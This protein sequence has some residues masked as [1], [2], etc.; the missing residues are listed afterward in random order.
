MT[1]TP[2]NHEDIALLIEEI[3]R[4]REG[5]A[6]PQADPG[7]WERTVRHFAGAQADR[8]VALLVELRQWRDRSAG[9]L[10]VRGTHRVIIEGFSDVSSSAALSDALDKASHY[11]SEQHDVSVTLQQLVELPKGGHRATVELHMTPLTEKDKAHP[12]GQDVEMKRLHERDYV[13]RRKHDAEHVK[14]LVFDHFAGIAGGPP[15]EIPDYFLINITDAQ[16]MNYMIEKQFFKAGRPDPAA[17][18]T[19]SPVKQQFVVRVK[20]S[21]QEPEPT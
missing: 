19:A 3:E 13:Q 1:N 20:R 9:D 18:P 5:A 4:I 10:P 8:I 16:I 15:V 6:Q 12:A 7:F 11:F 17:T 2:H 14:H 21:D